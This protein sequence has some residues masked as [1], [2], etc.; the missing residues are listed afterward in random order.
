MR[1]TA[2]GFGNLVTMPRSMIMSLDIDRIDKPIRTLRKFLKKVPKR[3]GIEQIHDLRTSSRRFETEVDAFG[4]SSKPNER[5][6]LPDLRRIRKRAGKIRDL[7]VLT[8]HLLGLVVNGEQDC[9]IELV[10]T[11]GMNRAK[12]VKKLCNLVLNSRVQLRRRLKRSS[13]KLD[14]LVKEAQEQPG[15]FESRR[16]RE[17][18]AKARQ[19]AEDLKS[20]ARLNKAN[21][22]PY[23]LKVKALLYVLQLSDSADKQEFV[24]KLQEIKDAIGEWHDWEELL[25]IA[26]ETLDH[27]AECKLL[28]KLKSVSE[29]KYKRALFLT[30]QM[31]ANFIC[32]RSSQQARRRQP[33]RATSTR[34][35]LVAATAI[36]SR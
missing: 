2:S 24:D 8:G 26:S 17:A 13:S 16:G 27:G 23:R 5:R 32:L 30:N 29:E 18:G 25:A 28:P 10:E 7:D 3:P 31:R 6:L 14:K 34:P 35:V 1:L 21:L 9:I 15:Y 12:H 4:L 22:H 19:L 20:P 36:T 11:F 33:T